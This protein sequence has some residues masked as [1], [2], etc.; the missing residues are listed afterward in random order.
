M[1]DIDLDKIRAMI[2]QQWLNKRQTSFLTDNNNVVDVDQHLRK[3]EL[4]F[5]VNENI[6]NISRF[7]NDQIVAIQDKSS[8]GD[9]C[10][11]TGD[12]I[13]SK[14]AGHKYPEMI[15]WRVTNVLPSYSYSNQRSLLDWLDQVV[16]PTT[17]E[18]IFGLL[19]VH[20]IANS[21]ITVQESETIYEAL[22]NARTAFKKRTDNEDKHPC[23]LMTPSTIKELITG[24]AVREKRFSQEALEN[25]FA[26]FHQVSDYD[27]GGNC[28]AMLV[29]KSV[30]TWVK[31]IKISQSTGR[32][33]STQIELTHDAF[34]TPHQGG[35][36]QVIKG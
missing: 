13:Q 34:I 20:A 1:V 6:V 28:K 22:C 24:E 3:G 25:L 23:L 26:P 18:S 17:D 10:A 5:R 4:E 9:F 19:T 36:M 15:N 16:I 35:A 21:Y 27:F 31:Y 11:D 14:S 32:S 12:G 2:N 29:D 30:L 33:N 7:E 8:L